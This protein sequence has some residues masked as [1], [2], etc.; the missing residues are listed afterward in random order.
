MGEVGEV[1][2]ARKRGKWARTYSLITFG[3]A[4]SFFGGVVECGAWVFA[5]GVW[6]RA[7]AVGCARE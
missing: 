2:L 5:R 6:W 7:D 1:A 4:R 3:A